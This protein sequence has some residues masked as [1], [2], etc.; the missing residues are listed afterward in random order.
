M[1]VVVFCVFCPV[2]PIFLSFSVILFHH[3]IVNGLPS[4]DDITLEEILFVTW[5]SFQELFCRGKI[6]LNVCKND[7][8]ELEKI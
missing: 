8:L 6:E 7:L 2:I 4:S 1:F 5:N 3:P